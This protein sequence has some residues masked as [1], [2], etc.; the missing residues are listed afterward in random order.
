MINRVVLVS[1]RFVSLMVCFGSATNGSSVNVATWTQNQQTGGGTVTLNGSLGTTAISLTTPA[2]PPNTGLAGFE[3]WTATP[4]TNGY[5]TAQSPTSGNTWVAIGV[6]QATLETLT[7]SSA[8]LNPILLFSFG[9]PTVTYNF[10]GLS[11]SL[12]S[13]HNAALAAGILTFP[14]ATDSDAD[15]VAIQVN[16]TFTTLSFVGNDVGRTD[17]QRFTVAVTSVPEPASWLMLGTGVLIVAHASRRGSR[18][19]KTDGSPRRRMARP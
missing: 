7:F 13:A 1:F 18:A 16:G 3:D 4:A 12:L 10:G 2:V 15:G 8:I 5:V 17:T 6:G 11:L 19:R 14:G 9:D